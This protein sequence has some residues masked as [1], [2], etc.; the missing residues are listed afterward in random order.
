MALREVKGEFLGGRERNDRISVCVGESRFP[1]EGFF[2]PW[3]G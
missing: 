2:G 1:R 3:K